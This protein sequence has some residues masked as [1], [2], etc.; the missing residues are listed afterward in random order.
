MVRDKIQN[1]K[2]TGSLF[3]GQINHKLKLEFRQENASNDC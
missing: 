1:K 2:R 3:K